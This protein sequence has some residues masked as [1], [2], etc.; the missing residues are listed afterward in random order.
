[1]ATWPV[2]VDTR[3]RTEKRAGF[4]DKDRIVLVEQDADTFEATLLAAISR[5]DRKLNYATGIGL[6]VLLS[7]IGALMTQVLR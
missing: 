4:S 2:T 3:S 5:V 1:M 6:A 7:L